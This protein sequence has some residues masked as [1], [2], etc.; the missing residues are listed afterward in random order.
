MFA[1]SVEALRPFYG[2]GG[3]AGCN[4]ASLWPNSHHE[5]DHRTLK[6]KFHRGGR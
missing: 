4:Q 3:E 6:P 2:A 1:G 5:L